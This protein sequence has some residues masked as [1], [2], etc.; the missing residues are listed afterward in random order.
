MRVVLKLLGV[1]ALGFLGLLV[2]LVAL[3][4]I[5]HALE[6]P[7]E[8]AKREGR[9]SAAEAYEAQQAAAAPAP[10]TVQAAVAAAGE[11]AIDRPP[12]VPPPAP[13]FR[14]KADGIVASED[15][16]ES[17]PLTVRQAQLRC[18]EAGSLRDGSKVWVVF[19]YAGSKA[20]TLNG[21]GLGRAKK[22]GW[23]TEL[24]AIEKAPSS[25]LLDLGIAFCET[26]GPTDKEASFP[27]D[28]TFL[29][30]D[31]IEPGTYRTQGGAG[32]YWA[33]L[34]DLSGSVDGILANDNASGS[35]I[36]HIKKTDKA[37]QSKGCGGWEMV[38]G[39]LV[40]LRPRRSGE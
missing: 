5:L 3:G 4:G 40:E 22:Y 33:R 16:G 12:E 8:K 30:G 24:D 35:A 9:T 29:V 26:Y 21:L 36:V 13:K 15:L 17:W 6:T 11:T 20:Y 25:N 2:A 19:M 23:Q 37:F 34:S 32:C 18:L 28:G 1:G 14:V 27:G 31:D 39:K 7:E 38:G 10:P